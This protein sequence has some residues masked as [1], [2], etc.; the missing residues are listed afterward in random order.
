[1]RTLAG[2]GLPWPKEAEQ[3]GTEMTELCGQGDGHSAVQQSEYRQA[4]SGESTKP[5]VWAVE[6]KSK[7]VDSVVTLL[8]IPLI[9]VD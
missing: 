7:L 4:I 3:S 2:L 9:L 5:I 1:V 6:K 8:P